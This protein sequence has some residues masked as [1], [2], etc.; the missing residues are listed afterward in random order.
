MARISYHKETIIPC[1]DCGSTVNRDYAPF[2][3][4]LATSDDME[5]LL[6]WVRVTPCFSCQE[7]RKQEEKRAKRGGRPKKDQG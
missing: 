6:A 3:N 5:R 7:K 2:L 4:W 1:P